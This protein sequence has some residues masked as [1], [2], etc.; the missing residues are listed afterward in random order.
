[1]YLLRIFRGKKKGAQ[2]RPDS[3][4]GSKCFS[5]KITNCIITALQLLLLFV[6]FVITFNKLH[7]LP[8]HSSK[9]SSKGTISTVQDTKPLTDREGGKKGR[10]EQEC[11]DSLESINI[12]YGNQV[13]MKPL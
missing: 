8:H 2:I 1:M 11:C 13:S 10:L 5:N 9:L 3:H 7:C 4:M 6:F 12:F